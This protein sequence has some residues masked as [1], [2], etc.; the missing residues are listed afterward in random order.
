MDGKGLDVDELA[1]RFGRTTAVVSVLVRSADA[2]P[3]F[4]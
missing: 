4:S 2:V 3:A 1:K